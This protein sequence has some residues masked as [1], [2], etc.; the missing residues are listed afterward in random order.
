LFLYIFGW[1]LLF[2]EGM[3]RMSETYVV[4]SK[5]GTS[6]RKKP[7]STIT[8]KLPKGVI[9]GKSGAV[10]YDS[11]ESDNEGSNQVH[12]EESAAKEYAKRGIKYP[13][14]QKKTRRP[15]RQ[16]KRRHPIKKK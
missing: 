10:Y 1:L 8:H 5:P 12:S 13:G 2:V 3:Y 4:K 16:T 7:K 15:R 11:D 6:H 14:G 9:I